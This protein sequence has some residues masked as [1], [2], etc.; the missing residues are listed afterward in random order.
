[1]EKVV[2]LFMQENDLKA[3]KLLYKITK[4][5]LIKIL[6]SWYEDYEEIS[7]AEESNEFY[8]YDDVMQYIWEKYELNKKQ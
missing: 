8:M 6:I 3:L 2:D 5:K 7:Q 1:M 4:D